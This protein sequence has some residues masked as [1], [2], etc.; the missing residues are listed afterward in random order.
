MSRWILIAIIILNIYIFLNLSNQ[1][2]LD[3]VSVV[4]QIP[5]KVGGVLEDLATKIEESK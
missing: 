2:R 4:A 3:T 5:V 1:S